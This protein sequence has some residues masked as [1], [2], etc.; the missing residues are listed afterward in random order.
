ML[1]NYSQLS[2]YAQLFL[3]LPLLPLPLLLAAVP[4]FISYALGSVCPN[5]LCLFRVLTSSET[6]V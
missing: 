5:A 3:L 1:V 2:I 6:E 4:S